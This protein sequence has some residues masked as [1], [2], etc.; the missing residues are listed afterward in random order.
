MLPDSSYKNTITPPP[1]SSPERTLVTTSRASEVARRSSAD[2]GAAAGSSCREGGLGREGSSESGEKTGREMRNLLRGI[3]SLQVGF[4]S[5]IGYKLEGQ[6][7]DVM[8]LKL[9][10]K[11]K[12]K[13][14]IL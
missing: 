9:I 4:L 5:S 1:P 10:V 7:S 11:K 8:A 14:S 3:K 12:K 13:K 2:G 6:L